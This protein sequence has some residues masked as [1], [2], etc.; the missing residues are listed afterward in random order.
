M[1]GAQREPASP[2]ITHL[3]LLMELGFCTVRLESD[4]SFPFTALWLL[5]EIETAL[6]CSTK[7]LPSDEFVKWEIK[8]RYLHIEPS[9]SRGIM[10]IHFRCYSSY[11]VSFVFR[12]LTW[13]IPQFSLLLHWTNIAHVKNCEWKNL[14]WLGFEPTILESETFFMQKILT[15][16]LSSHFPTP[17]TPSLD[18]P[19]FTFIENR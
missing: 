12:Y 1:L 16:S 11:L 5:R 4:K 8:H 2:V 15:T 14:K 18:P 19:H 9:R 6:E 17:P 3:K 13:V 10:R 7:I